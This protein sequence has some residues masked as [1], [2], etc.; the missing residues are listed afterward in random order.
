MLY[1]EALLLILMLIVGYS[2]LH[3]RDLYYSI[4]LFVLFS[5]FAVLLYIIL[6]APDVALLEAVI[7]ILFTI[8]FLAGIYKIGRWSES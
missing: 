6:G 2:A 7:G 4:L 1:F 3:V 8:F 5:V